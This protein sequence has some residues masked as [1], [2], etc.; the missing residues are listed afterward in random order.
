MITSYL[1]ISITNPTLINFNI[2]LKSTGAIFYL[3]VAYISIQ[4]NYHAFYVIS[5]TFNTLVSNL[6]SR[7]LSALAM[8]NAHKPNHQIF[9][10]S[11][12]ISLTQIS[13]SILLLLFSQA[14]NYN[15]LQLL[16]S[17]LQPPSKTKSLSKPPYLQILIAKLLP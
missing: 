3:S 13:V 14:M 12:I 8:D 17:L 1:S 5:L 2:N 10:I 7:I 9:M 11:P 16:T 6:L 4:D 15:L